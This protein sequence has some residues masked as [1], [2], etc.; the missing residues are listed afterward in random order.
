LFSVVLALP[1]LKARWVSYN[2]IKEAK[3]K[4]GQSYGLLDNPGTL[5]QVVWF[6]AGIPVVITMCILKLFS[7]NER[8]GHTY[9][10]SICYALL[11][12][13]FYTCAVIFQPSL[14]SAVMNGADRS[15]TSVVHLNAHLTKGLLFFHTIAAI[16]PILSINFP[17]ARMQIYLGSQ[18]LMAF[19]AAF[20]FWQA[21]FIKMKLTKCLDTS[22]AMSP[23]EKTL[24]MKTKLNEAQKAPLIMS[25][26]LLIVFIMFFVT[27]FMWNRAH[28]YFFPVMVLVFTVQGLK[29]A[30]TTLSSSETN[31]MNSSDRPENSSRGSRGANSGNALKP[32]LDSEGV[33]SF[34]QQKEGFMRDPDSI[35]DSTDDSYV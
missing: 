2:A 24:I 3:T 35:A 12:I 5:T 11:R 28:D 29:V 18:G 7:D 13:V 34:V 17:N 21:W 23:N 6:G 14:L 25:P 8:I 33:T 1:Y 16:L 31:K 19:T 26:M 4:K 9:G 30:K 10:V 27:P 22:Y 15:A 20:L 32:G